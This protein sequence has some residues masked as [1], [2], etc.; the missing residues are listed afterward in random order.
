MQQLATAT[1]SMQTMMSNLQ[2]PLQPINRSTVP[3]PITFTTPQT[4]SSWSG[5][6]G[7]TS[8]VEDTSMTDNNTT[9]SP[10]EY[11]TEVQDGEQSSQSSN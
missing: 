2:Q 9:N 4:P 8:W 11:Y 1:N 3:T 6:G 10:V 7:I 5:P